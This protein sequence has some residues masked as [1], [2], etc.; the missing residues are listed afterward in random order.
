M[1]F[2]SENLS[3]VCGS[4]LCS[5]VHTVGITHWLWSFRLQRENSIII[6][7]LSLIKLLVA[8]YSNAI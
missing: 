8:V 6:L 3:I 4:M 2:Q 5:L 1:E 7:A